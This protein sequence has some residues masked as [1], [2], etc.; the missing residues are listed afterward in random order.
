MYVDDCIIL[1]R[2]DERIKWLISS[3]SE[4]KE[5]FDLTDEGNISNYLGVDFKRNPDGSFELRQPY[6][7]DRIIKALDLPEGMNPSKNPAVKHHFI[8]TKMALKG[9]MLGI[10]AALLGC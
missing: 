1:G 4:G 3:L 8:K 9:S 2:N 6:L 5:N 10:I 7:I